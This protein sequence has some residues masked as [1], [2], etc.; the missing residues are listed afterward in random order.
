[1]NARNWFIVPLLLLAGC[2]APPAE[3]E[4]KK[5]ITPVAVTKPMPSGE[6]LS[7]ETMTIIP[8]TIRIPAIGVE[9]S[10]EK[11]GT[12]ANGQMGVPGNVDSAGWYEPGTKPGDHGNAVIAGHVDSKSGPAIFYKLDQLKKND[13]IEVED[14]AGNILTF[15]VY[16]LKTF[17]RLEA[18]VE[19]IFGFTYRK[20]LSLITCTGDFNRS[21]RTHEKR[22]VVYAELLEK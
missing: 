10:V 14:E 12:L 5:E 2:A 9:A 13:V 1:M 11:V 17:P 18:P 3:A 7:S 8:A 16:D 21:E 6:V 22:L 20:T 15:Q 19:E 4:P